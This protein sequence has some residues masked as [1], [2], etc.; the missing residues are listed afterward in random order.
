MLDLMPKKATNIKD[1]DDMTFEKEVL[2]ASM[3]APVIVDFWAT[4]CGPCKQLTPVL[5]KVV[6]AAQGVTL[7]KVD[8]DKAKNVAGALQIQTVPTVYA[9][10]KGRAVDGFAGGQPESS[11]KAFVERVKSLVVPAAP[12]GADTAKLMLDA[13]GFFR[14]GK[15]EDAMA[16]FSAVLDVDAENMEALGG[17]GWCLLSMG[18]A[19]SA[20]EML[21]QL[22]PEQMKSPRLSGLNFILTL[23]PEGELSAAQE[24]IASGAIEQG[25]ETLVALI[26]KDR[27]GKARAFLLQ[28]FEALGNAHPLTSAGRRKL[29]AV[30]FS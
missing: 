8:V 2:E 26:K 15:L 4:W 17:I 21:T 22:T 11:V 10:Y 25:I 9:F 18:D 16:R 27:E 14:E 5:E 19:E 1:A 12:A 24:K 23:K 3:T 6:G 7:V 28:V 20:R 30:L 13:D 29:S